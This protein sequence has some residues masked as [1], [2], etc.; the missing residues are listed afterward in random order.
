MTRCQE[1]GNKV[2]E[3]FDHITVDCLT[4]TTEEVATQME[5]EDPGY[6]EKLAAAI[7]EETGQ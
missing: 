6:A 1:C 3:Y 7:A 4:M 5:I 2:L